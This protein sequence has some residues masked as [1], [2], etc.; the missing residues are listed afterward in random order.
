MVVDAF[1]PS[2]REEDEVEG[3][4]SQLSLQLPNLGRGKTFLVAWPFCFFDLQ[5]EPQY[6]S[7][8]F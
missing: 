5:L 4:R 3:D 8:G 2:T 6:L 1:N 7:L